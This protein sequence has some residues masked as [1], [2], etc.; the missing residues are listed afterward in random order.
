MIRMS[1]DLHT[2]MAFLA[3]HNAALLELLGSNADMMTA[4]RTRDIVRDHRMSIF[5]GL[6]FMTVMPKPV[7]PFDC[8]SL[9]FITRFLPALKAG[10]TGPALGDLDLH[11]GQT[12]R[13]QGVSDVSGCLHFR[14]NLSFFTISPPGNSSQLFDSN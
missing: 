6:I 3:P 8:N 4:V 11:A 1:S 7:A 5:L 12:C 10:A 13:Y 2:H 14:H 9:R